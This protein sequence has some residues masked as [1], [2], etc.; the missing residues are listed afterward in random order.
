MK[1]IFIIDGYPKTKKQEQVLHDC[2]ESIKPIGWDILLVSHYPVPSQIQEKVEYCIYDKNNLF[3]PPN[4]SPHVFF[5]N[6]VFNSKIY[7][8]GHALAITI[9]IN[10]LLN[11]SLVF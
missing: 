9:S 3:V 1:K 11:K 6:E 10:V 8:G 2:I 7:L 5:E 4:I